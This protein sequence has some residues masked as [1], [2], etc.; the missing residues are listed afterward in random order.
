MSVI[1]AEVK[2]FSLEPIP[3]IFLLFDFVYGNFNLVE[4]VVGRFQARFLSPEVAF[5]ITCIS[6]DMADQHAKVNTV[7]YISVW[8][9]YVSPKVF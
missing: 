3:K 7:C 1:L 4:S 8:E 5:S 2:Y 6:R 9:D